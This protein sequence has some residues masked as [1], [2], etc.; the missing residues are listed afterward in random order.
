[1][2]I[3]CAKCGKHFSSIEGTREHSGHCRETSKGEPIRWVSARNS[4]ITPEEWETLMNLINAR[5]VSQ[6]ITPS[7]LEPTAMESTGS[8]DSTEPN[9]SIPS[10]TSENTQRIPNKKEAI[11]KKREKTSNFR[12]PTWLIALTGPK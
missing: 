11:K 5:D 6:T 12:I 10:T 9:I 8:E 3:I 4:K 7:N 2:D 1:M